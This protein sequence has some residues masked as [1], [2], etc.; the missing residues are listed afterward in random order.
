MP[1]GPR[2]VR[3]GHAVGALVLGDLLLG[4]TVFSVACLAIFTAFG[5][6]WLDLVALYQA[7]AA[8][9][10]TVAQTRAAW[11]LIAVDPPFAVLVGFL[12]LRS[13]RLPWRWWRAAVGPS[14]AVDPA[15]RIARASPVPMS[16]GALWAARFRRPNDGYRYVSLLLPGT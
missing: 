1:L 5:V 8:A 4:C 2:W 11:G 15:P 6:S 3:I 16:E 12:G 14:P 10:G 9:F 13:L 7:H